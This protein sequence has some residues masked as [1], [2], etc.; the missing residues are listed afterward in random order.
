MKYISD[1]G[2]SR[3]PFIGAAHSGTLLLSPAGRTATPGSELSVAR[4]AGQGD[5]ARCAN[6]AFELTRRSAIQA[7]SG[8]SRSSTPGRWPDSHSRRGSCCVWRLATLAGTM[9]LGGA[10]WSI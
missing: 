2:S 1:L 5:M 7:R 9:V 6:K 8:G 10:T 4:S 3:R